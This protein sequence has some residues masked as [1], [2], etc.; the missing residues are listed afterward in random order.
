M[1]EINTVK[2]N[3]WLILGFALFLLIFLLPYGTDG[4]TVIVSDGRGVLFGGDQLLFQDN[5]IITKDGSPLV[6]IS[7]DHLT[8]GE[9]AKSREKKVKRNGDLIVLNRIITEDDRLVETESGVE[10]FVNE[11]TIVSSSMEVVQFKD[12]QKV[13]LT[14]KAVLTKGAKII[15]AIAAMAVIFFLS[16]AIPFPAVA[17]L[18]VIG[19]V[20][21][22]GMSPN[23]VAKSFF[24]DSVFFIMG[25]LMIAT[26][27]IKQSL[28]KRIAL[29]ILTKTGEKIERVVFGI[30][31]TTAILAAFIANHTVAAMF[32]PVGIALTV[33]SGKNLK[34]L[35]KLIMFSIAYGTA[36]GSL[37][38]PSG[39]ARNVI[40][41]EYWRQMY[42][43]NIG[44]IDWLLYAF[45]MVLVMIPLTT[46]LLLRV[47]KPEVKDLSVAMKSIQKEVGEKGKM[48]EKEWMSIGIFLVTLIMWI[49]VGETIGLGFVAIIGATLFIIF[50]L[51]D[52]NDYNR[53]TD[54]GVVLLYAGAISLG[55]AMKNTGAARWLAES[56][57]TVLTPIGADAGLLLVAAVSILVMIVSNTMSDGA[58]VAVTG[59]ITLNMAAISGTS[60]ISVGF[61]T[62]ISS[63]FAYLLVVGTPSNAII[64]ASGYIRSTDFV[65]AGFL[66]VVMSV[67]VLLIMAMTWWKILGVD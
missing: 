63:A 52:W 67:A 47:F 16:E 59:P 2:N 56:F 57:L 31:A 24:S 66:M 62:A 9:I 58:A 51:V 40:M 3:R 18:I 19:E 11:D 25:S 14:E 39:G 29:F 4:N 12:G 53:G 5:K 30:V 44:Y 48:G 60:L 1:L 38:T 41:I 65:K 49:T 50:K 17:F 46:L 43:I 13:K 27:I 35:G 26:A 20:I 45:P 21:F 37:G 6:T 32:L 7:G 34:S 55:L 42:D 36:I 22:I 10:I 61:A 15:I 33:K 64:Y 8:V 54:W 28:D 23:V